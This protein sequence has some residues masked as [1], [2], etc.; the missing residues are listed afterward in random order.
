MHFRLDA[1]RSLKCAVQFCKLLKFPREF[2]YGKYMHTM[3]TE[4]ISYIAR[5]GKNSFI[6]I[7]I[8]V[9]KDAVVIV[10]SGWEVMEVG[11]TWEREGWIFI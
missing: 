6:N 8:I 10:G 5:I 9:V 7:N 4:L 11:L 2:T 3:T 1:R